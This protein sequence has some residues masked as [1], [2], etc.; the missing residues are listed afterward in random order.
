MLQRIREKITGWVAGVIIGLIALS[1]IFWGVGDFGGTGRDA[2]AVVDGEEIPRREFELVYQRQLFQLTEAYGGNVPEPVRLELRDR[3]IEGLV[4]ERLLLQRVEER[5]YRVPDD[6]L[7]ESIQGIDAF[8]VGGRFSLDAY[9]ARL[10]A[11]GMS[12]G[13][14]EEQQRRAIALGQLQDAVASTGFFTPTEFRRYI[15]LAQQR[16]EIAWASFAVDEYREAIEP[17]SDEMVT[18]YYAANPDQFMRPESVD[19]EYVEIT[20]AQV[21]AGLPADEAALREYYQRTV[22]DFALPEQ[23]RARHILI[24][25]DSQRDL[26]EARALA[27]SLRQRIEAGEEFAELAA[28]YSDDE[29]SAQQGGD[30]GWAEQGFFVEPFERVL[31]TLEPGEVSEPV[32]TVFGFH[33]IRLDEVRAGEL[34]AFEDIRE[35]LAEDFMRSEAEN[36]FIDRANAL[37]DAAFEYPNDLRAI[38]E[39]EN[40]QVQRLPGLTRAGSPMFV[41][42]A[43]LI[44]AAFT[45][46]VIFDGEVSP[47]LE[48]SDDRVIMLTVTE[49]YPSEVRPLQ[50]VV[51]SIR[52][53]LEQQAAARLAQEAGQQF[54]EALRAAEDAEALEA[55]FGRTLNE[56]RLYSRQEFNAVPPAVLFAAF[57][58][59]R[60]PAGEPSIDSVRLDSGDYAVFV[61]G[62][63]RAGDPAEIDQSL[64]DIEKNRLASQTGFQEFALYIGALE[65][66]ARVRR[67]AEAFEEEFF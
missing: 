35:E 23:R 25:A 49:H 39:A 61:L 31:F 5:G 17:V 64:R 44:D 32:E 27:Q 13:M 56:P 41:D 50:E 12:P 46:A 60:P 28:E 21:S 51:D 63:V 55:R 6:V 4:Q 15:E 36:E 62:D 40:L 33:V 11:Q 20:L 29:G 34:P 48:L 8:Q 2:V 14:F 1:F 18:D 47:L 7:A 59:P 45:P 54:L 43:P 38:A 10:T 52:R 16:R 9:R 26:N 66:A 19:V 67:R 53:N 42:S 30:L 24:A 65:A 37:A 22:A 57:E 58:R 3:V